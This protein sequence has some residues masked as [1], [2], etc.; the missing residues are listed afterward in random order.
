MRHNDDAF[1]TMLLTAQLSPDREEYVRPLSTSEYHQLADKLREVRLGTLRDL[2]D[3]DMSGIMIKLGYS[4]DEALRICMLLGR[5]LPFSIQIEQLYGQG[6]DFLTLHDGPYPARFREQLQKKAPPMFYLAGRS[7]LFRQPCVAILGPR[8]PNPEAEAAARKLVDGAIREGYTV[9]TDGTAGLGRMAESEALTRGG[10]AI[11]LLGGSLAERIR[12]PLLCDAL[13]RRRAVALSLAHPDAPPTRSHAL[14][15][16]KCLYALSQAVFVF[17]CDYKNDPIW[18]GA[19]EALRNK[20]CPFVYCWNTDQY[21]GNRPLIVQG[22]IPVTDMKNLDFA[23]MAQSWRGAMG[24]Q[25]CLF[26]WKEP[27]IR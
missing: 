17:G 6:I 5:T 7:E 21:S 16:N 11:S 18:D 23:Q 2:I 22:A 26:D 15:R 13:A 24:E 14:T 4:E 25:M 10:R 27:E 12:Q 3:L 8:T 19:T 9:A 1:A 20:Y